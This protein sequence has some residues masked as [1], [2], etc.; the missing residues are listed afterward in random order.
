[1]KS[2]RNHKSMKTKMIIC[3]TVIAAAMLAGVVGYFFLNGRGEGVTGGLEA[4]VQNKYPEEYAP[5][6]IT[7]TCFDGS[8]VVD[9][10]LYSI[11]FQKSENYVMNKELVKSLDER[12]AE[13]MRERVSQ[14]VD[15]LFG[16]SGDLLVTEYDTYAD[17]FSSFFM[18]DSLYIDEN[19][20]E[21]SKD[22]LL[23][24]FM[25]DLSDA[26]WEA[27][28][29]FDSDKSLLFSDLSY[30]LRGLITIRVYNYDGET[31]L[32]YFLPVTEMERGKTYQ[33]VVD[34]GFIYSNQSRTGDDVRICS[35]ENLQ[36]VSEKENNNTKG[37]YE[38]E[39]E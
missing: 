10:V 16:T 8:A 35:I 37:T 11:P 15:E 5:T 30:Y 18:E 22:V 26:G 24:E 19:G 34:I 3:T 29:T 32:S 1:M 36:T 2:K 38:L 14:M 17:K 7:E 25:K 20:R 12:E 9:S 33:F 21:V 23:A 39:K 31:D 27:E 4:Q 6:Y 28:V 13:V